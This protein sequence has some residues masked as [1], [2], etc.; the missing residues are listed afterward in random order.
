MSEQHGSLP[1]FDELTQLASQATQWVLL[2]NAVKDGVRPLLPWNSVLDACSQALGQE[3]ACK[4]VSHDSGPNGVQGLVTM[5][6]AMLV[7]ERLFPE[8][9]REHP[10]RVWR[11]RPSAGRHLARRV[12]SGTRRRSDGFCLSSI[13]RSLAERVPR[14][15]L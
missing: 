11:G 13:G 2:G 4:I 1:V 5:L 7:A 15:G 10:G 9:F 14:C 3:F 8:E 6:G 12:P